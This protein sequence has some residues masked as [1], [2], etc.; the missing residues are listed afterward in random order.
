[1]FESLSEYP[2]DFVVGCV[3]VAGV[4]CLWLLFKLIKLALWTLVWVV[5]GT[6]ILTAAAFLLR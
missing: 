6:V 4:G 1:M 3:L 5:L 2:H